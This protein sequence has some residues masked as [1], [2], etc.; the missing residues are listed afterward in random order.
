MS[1]ATRLWWVAVIVALF[2]LFGLIIKRTNAGDFLF[3]IGHRLWQQE[4]VAPQPP[5]QQALLLAIRLLS[6]ENS[7][8][9]SLLGRGGRAANSVLGR[10]LVRPG[11]RAPYDTLIIDVGAQH[12]IT[13]GN[14][15]I[16]DE[17]TIIGRVEEVYAHESK[18]TLFSS[19]GVLT[20]ISVG[21]LNTPS[22]AKGRGAGNYEILFP[23]DADIAVD[24]I[25]LHAT[26]PAYALGVVAAIKENE[27]D[28][29][30]TVLFA[31]PITLQSL[32]YVHV[33]TQALP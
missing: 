13:K 32:S 23:R 27:T 3:S 25:I 18:V 12:G 19:P 4:K 31:S 14:A 17:K 29:F 9:E 22:E 1:F 26:N 7:E 5:S 21:E 10:V 33:I 28:Q 6:K 15:V 11:A 30:K 24:D 20:P 8:L 16:V 2:C